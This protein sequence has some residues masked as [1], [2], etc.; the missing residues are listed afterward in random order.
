MFW[1]PSESLID[2]FL[3]ACQMTSLTIS[4]NAL[5]AIVVCEFLLQGFDIFFILDKL[6]VVSQYLS[7]CSVRKVR[8][9]DEYL[10]EY[11]FQREFSCADSVFSLAHSRGTV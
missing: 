8:I 10:V 4:P 7:L 11:I 3:L 5:N 9:F 2:F 6:F 1:S